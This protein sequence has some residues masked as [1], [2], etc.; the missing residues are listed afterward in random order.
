[1]E[2]STQKDTY[3]VVPTSDSRTFGFTFNIQDRTK[4]EV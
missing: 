4:N 1:M 3:M 2:A